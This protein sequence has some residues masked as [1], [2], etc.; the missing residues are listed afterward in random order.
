MF[1]SYTQQK[2]KT[3]QPLYIIKYFKMVAHFLERSSGSKN[4]TQLKSKD[5]MSRNF[6]FKKL[7]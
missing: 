5:K 2:N 1:N 4:A 6:S 3:K 7:M